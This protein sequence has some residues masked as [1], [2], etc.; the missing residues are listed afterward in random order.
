VAA[1]GSFL[2]AK[3]HGGRWLLRLEDLD[4][5]RVVPGAAEQMLRTLEAFG[6]GWDGA[7]EYQSRRQE[8]YTAALARLSG[9]G[10]TFEC[11]CSRREL[12]R[13]YPG[14]CRNGLRRAGPTATRFRVPAETVSFPD[15]IHGECRFELAALGDFVVRRRDGT[16]AYQLAV[17]VDDALQGV[18]DVVRGADLLDNTPWQLA[19]QRAL[20]LP[21]PRYAHLPLVVEARG[22]KLAKSRQALALEPAAAGRQLWQALELL[23]QEPPAELKL[24]LPRSVL[25]WGCGHW[26]VA[27]VPTAPQVANDVGFSALM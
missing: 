15:R 11:S 17:V 10:R 18:T 6:L 22:G 8:H 23:G 14:T 24:E 2:D 16:F 25:D 5:A 27:R 12:E 21:P 1:V 13:A 9:A 26:R 20:G 7:V 19:L 4:R 3:H